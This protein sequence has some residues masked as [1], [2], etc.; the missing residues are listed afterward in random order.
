MK[1]PNQIE[2]KTPA[3][4]PRPGSEGTF[5]NGKISKS[6]LI[7]KKK[8]NYLTERDYSSL[9]ENFV[10]T[11]TDQGKAFLP[12]NVGPSQRKEMCKF[13]KFLQTLLLNLLADRV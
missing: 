3:Q 10:R 12:Q 1:R 9:V 7:K 5:K 6:Q 13:S 8:K 11:S 4:S 2:I